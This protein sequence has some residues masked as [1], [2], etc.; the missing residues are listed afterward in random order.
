V[1]WNIRNYRY[2]EDVSVATKAAVMMMT[3]PVAVME[4]T[5]GAPS[6][7]PP[8][9]LRLSIKYAIFMDIPLRSVGGA[10]AMT[11][12]TLVIVAQGG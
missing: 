1:A 11:V 3:V 7:I 2:V 4:T 10:M 8:H 9:M 12:A 6:V 5:V